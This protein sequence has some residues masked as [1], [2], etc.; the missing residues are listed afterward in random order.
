MQPNAASSISRTISNALIWALVGLS[1]SSV[2][3]QYLI[4]ENYIK[5][6]FYTTLIG[7]IINVV[8][9]YFFIPIWGIE[10]AAFVTAFS[11]LMVFI[12]S[13]FFRKVRIIFKR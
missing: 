11:Y 6:F 3:S 5:I 1:L 13:L 12:S 4:S 8:L 9:N 7:A 2:I 10:G